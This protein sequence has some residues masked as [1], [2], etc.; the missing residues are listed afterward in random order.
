[1]QELKE[2]LRIL[3]KSYWV[4]KNLSSYVHNKNN[5]KLGDSLVNFLYSVAKS[6]VSEKPTGTKVSDSILSEAY[7]A[8]LWWKTETLKLK[9]DKSRVADAVEALILYFWLEEN[10][11]LEML[12]KPLFTLLNPKKLHHPKEEQVAASLSFCGLLDFLFQVYSKQKKN[13]N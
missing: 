6:L 5:S 10:V 2:S 8:S 1:M 3:N 4:D 11:S 7:K 9:G 12:I 13:D